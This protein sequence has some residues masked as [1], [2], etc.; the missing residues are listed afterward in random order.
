[1]RKPLPPPPFGSLYGHLTVAGV[2]FPV[3]GTGRYLTVSCSCGKVLNVK[4]AKLLSGHTASCGCQKSPRLRELA[5]KH[6]QRHT[7]IYYVWGAMLQRCNNP[8]NP[9]Y[10]NYGGRGI[11]VCVRWLAFEKFF[12]DM[13][14]PPFE[15]AMLERK[16][17]DKNYTPSNCC[18]ATRTQQ[19][20]NTRRNKVKETA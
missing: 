12:K 9:A 14:A 1:M 16:N 8:K 15:G 11:K 4:L 19:N 18:W 10:R 6:G 17:N 7:K 3:K 2:P 5:T 20:N 13:G